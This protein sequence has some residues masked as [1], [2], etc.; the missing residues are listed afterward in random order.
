MAKKQ[1]TFSDN[2]CII[3]G[4][5]GEP[6]SEQ[7]NAR[8]GTEWMLCA[9]DRAHFRA[10]ISRCELLLKSVLNKTNNKN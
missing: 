3:H 4:D 2:L 8:S 9:I 10:R 1:V 6:S 5:E 7:R